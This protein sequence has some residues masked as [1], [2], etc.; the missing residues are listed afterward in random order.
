MEGRKEG[1]GDMNK[2]VTRPF[3]VKMSQREGSS[4]RRHRQGG[5]DPSMT[6][7]DRCSSEAACRKARAT[8]RD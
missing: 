5:S 8:V 7:D 4:R 3:L 1:T 2:G 6:S